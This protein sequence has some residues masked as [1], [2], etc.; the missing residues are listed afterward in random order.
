MG[1]AQ[2]YGVTLLRLGLGL[3]YVM[4]GYLGLVVLGPG[5]LGGYVIRMG[6]PAAYAPALAWYAIVVHLVGGLFLVLGLWTRWAAHAPQPIKASAV[7]LLHY[8]QGILKKARARRPKVTG[9]MVALL[10]AR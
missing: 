6:Y 10:T 3:I 5:A 8:K 4:H 1:T 2:H 7:A 9:A